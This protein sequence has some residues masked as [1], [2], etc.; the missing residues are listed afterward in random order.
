[1]KVLK[2]KQSF[3]L[4]YFHCPSV[5]SIPS[6]SGLLILPYL[7]SSSLLSTPSLPLI[8]PSIARPLPLR[9]CIWRGGDEVCSLRKVCL[10]DWLIRCLVRVFGE[11]G[12]ETG[13]SGCC[14]SIKCGGSCKR[15]HAP[16]SGNERSGSRWGALRLIFD[17]WF[18]FFISFFF[19]F[20][21]AFELAQ[22]H[23]VDILRLRDVW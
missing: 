8:H 13:E 11:K 4:S 7:S 1:M 18:L 22:W 6:L 2:K 21:S 12:D 20:F 3:L 17:V 9:T 16:Q 14:L 15:S 5:F 23:G 19:F 10:L